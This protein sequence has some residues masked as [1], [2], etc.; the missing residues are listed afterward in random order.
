MSGWPRA[1]ISLILLIIG[2]AAC[3]LSSPFP[4]L[5]GA[6]LILVAFG[7]AL[8]PLPMR[9]RE[10]VDR[11]GARTLWSWGVPL[12]F[13]TPLVCLVYH[14][15]LLGQMPWAEGQAD[16]PTHLYQ[17]WLLV[18]KMIPTGRLTGWSD[19]RWSG[20]PALTLYPI[21]GPLWV[22]S[23]RTLTLGL[24]SW[25]ATYAL[26]ILAMLT[27]NV[28]AA[29]VVG[30][31]FAGP[32]AG[33]ISAVLVLFERGSARQGGDFYAVDVGV[34]PVTMAIGPFLLCLER[35]WTWIR[36]EG[37]SLAL[38]TACA[39][40]AWTMLCHPM[41]VPV[42]V[43]ALPTLVIV[44]LLQGTPAV[45]TVSSAVAVALVGIGLVGFWYGPFLYYREFSQ[46]GGAPYRSLANL[47]EGLAMSTLLPR[48]WSLALAVGLG[49]L[50]LGFARRSGMALISSLTLVLLLAA[51]A[52]PLE[53][54]EGL[55]SLSSSVQQERFLI[56]VRVLF[57]LLAGFGVATLARA[58]AKQVSIDSWRKKLAF[59]AITL[60]V[61]PFVVPAVESGVKYLVLPIMEFEH[62]PELQHRRDL[63]ELC[64]W[65]REQENPGPM[66]PRTAWY[67]GFGHHEYN[68]APMYCGTAQIIDS[69][70][71]TFWHRSGGVSEREAR[72]FNVRWVVSD[73]EI[74]G[75]ED[76]LDLEQV[77]GRLHVYGVRGYRP[78]RATHLGSGSVEI[79]QFDDEL[80]RGRISG[81]NAGERV[82]IHVT[83]FPL[84][85]AEIDGEEVEIAGGHLG[86]PRAD[87][88]HL[89][90]RDGVFELRY[91][92]GPPH[93]IGA[94]LSV[95]SLCLLVL[96]VLRRF[97]IDLLD[98]LLSK[99]PLRSQVQ[100]LSPALRA[101]L[102]GV[103]GSVLFLGLL[104]IPG[105]SGPA[106]REAPERSH[107]PGWRALAD[108]LDEARVWTVGPEGRS[109][110]SRRWDGRFGKI[111]PPTV[112]VDR[113]V[114][115][116]D[117]GDPR[118]VLA[119]RPGVGE[120]VHIRFPRLA[121]SRVKGEV[122]RGGR[123]VAKTAFAV[124]IGHRREGIVVNDRLGRWQSFDVTSDTAS[125]PLEIVVRTEN[126]RGR[127]VLLDAVW[128]SR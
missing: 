17:G 57:C 108:E 86:L 121:V 62:G 124:W 9:S 106:G 37:S 120:E 125:A 79:E 88:I 107:E 126:G 102:I 60:L 47:A 54:A 55:V 16:H 70:A 72:A 51:A 73:R 43:L 32:W 81:S 14:P 18:E 104:T 36:K 11:L 128:S 5:F 68:N 41:Y 87:L 56:P 80:I 69:P 89:P 34:W 99:A 111:L 77:F 33:L 63:D 75:R 101:V 49:G 53:L 21:G 97:E 90:A 105:Y 30:R 64:N 85:R 19:L 122:A 48:F 26:A 59:A 76:Y 27:V 8:V 83:R 113:H 31:R 4:Q 40:A 92:R 61:A 118:R 96:L 117:L 20:Y 119:I 24:L 28:S 123:G 22:A 91:Q 66:P 82:V 3:L 29:Y 13:L 58:C 84:W 38:P 67:V 95:L 35:S 46:P 42:L 1:L 2:G 127:A 23:W 116:L 7:W 98:K 112:I 44:S 78:T 71:E 93:W 25:E 115:A 12:L 103:F 6:P 50:L 109:E 45:R 10:L 94:I 74:D 15:L 39:L 110:L 52:T 114:E 65:M 100:R